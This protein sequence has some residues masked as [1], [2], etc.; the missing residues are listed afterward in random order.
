MATD[1]FKFKLSQNA[2]MIYKHLFKYITVAA[3]S[4]YAQRGENAAKRRGWRPCINS[5]GKYIDDH[6]KS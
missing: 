4:I 5:H 1:G 2:C 3:L 6:G